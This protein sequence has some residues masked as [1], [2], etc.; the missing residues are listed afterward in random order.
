[1][2][3]GALV[4]LGADPVAMEER[5][6]RLPLPGLRLQVGEVEKNGI[7]AR[8]VTPRFA[9]GGKSFR[10][11]GQVKEALR[12]GGLE[13]ATVS[14][15]E[16]VFQRLAEAEAAVH[17]KTAGTVHFHELGNPDTLVDVV[18]VL[19][20]WSDLGID[21][22]YAS[23]V[24][25]G[26][27]EIRTDHGILPVPA[28]AT[29]ELLKGWPVFTDGEEGEKTTPTGAALVTHLCLPAQPLPPVRL[30]R[31]GYGA[32]ERDFAARP[33]CLQIL[34]GEKSEGVDG[35][36]A[37][38]VETN[39]DDV[40]PQIFGHL[41]ALL[42]KAG[43]MEAYVTPV[44][45]K[46]GRPG[47][48]LTVLVRPDDVEEIGR[49]V[50]RE[51]GTLGYRYGKVSRRKIRREIREVATEHGPVRVKIGIMDGHVVRSAPEYDDCLRISRASGQ[52]LKDVM[53]E[54]VRALDRKK[55][56]P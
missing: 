22:G 48:L 55:P 27:G 11:L 46:K 30:A 20:A 39:L 25:L 28:P 26:G 23:A 53:E 31:T 36:E 2:L 10:T 52:P 56:V 9:G 32:G 40:N 18:G 3:L 51:T 43:A 15:A 50:F 37:M 14:R 12:K 41:T 19:L 16:K 45:M 6:R 34:L 33:N 13:G 4:D 21:E 44:V 38:V 17:G 1:M 8:K 7:R 47:H 29:A 5:L 35:E 54:A 24:N 42:L 49:L